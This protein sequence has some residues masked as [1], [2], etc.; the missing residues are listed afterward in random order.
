MNAKLTL[1]LDKQIISS[2]KKFAKKRGTS[3][4]RMV[5]E[6]LEETTDK[7]KRGD[8]NASPLVRKLGGIFADSKHLD[9][10]TVRTEYLSKKYLKKH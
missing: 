2:A 6:Y 8:V 10:D 9:L 5:E 1:S 7:K 3:I 4:S